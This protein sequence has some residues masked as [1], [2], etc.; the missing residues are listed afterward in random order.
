MEETNEIQPRLAC[1]PLSPSSRELEEAFTK[2]LSAMH[3]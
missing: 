2:N 1:W 3:F